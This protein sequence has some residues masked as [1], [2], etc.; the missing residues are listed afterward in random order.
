MPAALREIRLWGSR[1]NTAPRVWILSPAQGEFLKDDDV[2]VIGKVD[3][4][5]VQVTVNGKSKHVTRLNNLFAARIALKKE[6]DPEEDKADRNNNDKADEK[7]DLKHYPW[8]ATI[9]AIVTDSLGREGSDTVTVYPNVKEDKVPI[10]VITSPKD[11]TIL[12]ATSVTV[13]VTLPDEWDHVKEVNVNGIQAT[14]LDGHE[15]DEGH[16]DHKDPKDQQ[17]QKDKEGHRDK[18]DHKVRT[19]TAQVPL[20]EGLNRLAATVVTQRGYQ[21]TGA[22]T[23]YN[24]TLPPVVRPNTPLAG[25]VLADSALT[26]QGLAGDTT[27]VGVQ[28]NGLPAALSEGIFSDSLNLGEGPNLLTITAKDALGRATTQQIGVMVDSQPPVV[29]I[30][31][32]TREAILTAEP[33][34]VTGSVQDATSTSVFINGV[35]ATISG[36]PVNG[37]FTA[38]VH[39]S[40]GWN[41]LRAVAFDAAEHPASDTLQVLLDTQPPLPFAPVADPAG[42]TP[43]PT[44]IITFATTDVTSGMDHYELKIDDGAYVTVMSPYTL[45]PLADG[46]HAITV[47]AVDRAGWETFGSVRVYI[48]ATPPAAFTPVAD[49]AGWTSK[50]TPAITF[51]TTDATSGIDHYELKVGNEALAVVTSP[52]TLPA[53]PDGEQVVTVRAVDKAGNVTEG[54]TKI[55]ID[56]IPPGLPIGLELI[57]GP[58]SITARWQPNPEA[59]VI[60]YVLRRE[61]AFS[62]G[63]ATRTITREQGTSY[64]DLDVTPGSSYA[65]Q[66]QAVDH[67]QNASPFTLPVQ[68]RA[69]MT[70]TP[71][72][73]ASGGTV[74]YENVQLEIPQGALP[75]STMVTVVTVSPES[76]PPVS[77]A[78]NVRVGPAYNFAVTDSPDQIT[79]GQQV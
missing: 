50:T 16:K 36:A 56:T 57:P 64:K 35:T 9:T 55:C 58:D 27:Q 54:Q 21:R 43:V 17:G 74:K 44:P 1:V 68:A 69:G 39:L 31:F 65:Y 78:A 15:G 30:D 61:P 13:T 25:D 19:F 76:T 40:E 32:P 48:D 49:P 71:V 33:V 66:L 63:T 26:V 6:K 24:D 8:R 59:D 42:W 29:R 45:P 52:H 18:K 4:P 51:A 41:T 23:V 79:N 11:E 5:L 60:H 53:Q 67:A 22:I 70:I 10:P 47:K 2:E 75:Q 73:S 34:T 62:D 46:I 20:E 7:T 37:R 3:N 12:V 38:P 77:N 72:D 28:V 14:E